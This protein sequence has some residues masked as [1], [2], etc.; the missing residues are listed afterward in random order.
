M[1]A[2]KP[3]TLTQVANGSY[4]GYT[5]K[6]YVIVGDVPV[7]ASAVVTLPA[8]PASFADL[9]AARTAVEALRAAIATS[10]YFN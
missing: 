3:I 6:P 5:P 9:A 2:P 1:V 7:P 4:E 10:P 8:T